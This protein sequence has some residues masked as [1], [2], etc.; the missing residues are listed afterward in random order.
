MSLAEGL[1]LKFLALDRRLDRVLRGRYKHKFYQF[2]PVMAIRNSQAAVNERAR[3][4][5]GIRSHYGWNQ[6]SHPEII[7]LFRESGPMGGRPPGPDPW[8]RWDTP[9]EIFDLGTATM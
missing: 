7:P 2:P 3:V 6:P 5:G 9:P 1:Y 8:L 4:R